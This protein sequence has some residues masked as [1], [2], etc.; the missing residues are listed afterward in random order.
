MVDEKFRNIKIDD[1]I[2]STFYPK[3]ATKT[4]FQGKK[5]CVKNICK[6]RAPFKTMEGESF[7]IELTLFQLDLDNWVPNEVCHHTIGTFV[8]TG[9]DCLFCGK[10]EDKTMICPFLTEHRSFLWEKIKKHKS[11]RLRLLVGGHLK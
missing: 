3:L 6:I 5:N 4:I 9:R 8:I 7:S 10:S 1:N 2:Q 11:L